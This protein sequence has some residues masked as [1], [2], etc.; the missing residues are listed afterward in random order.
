M[1]SK[2]ELKPNVTTNCPPIFSELVEECCNFE[3][4]ERPTFQQICDKLKKSDAEKLWQNPA[5]INL[6]EK[7]EDYNVNIPS[8]L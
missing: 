6:N 4:N 5:S 8:I 7:S 1:I 2:R 3:T